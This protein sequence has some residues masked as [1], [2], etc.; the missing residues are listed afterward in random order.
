MKLAIDL[1]GTGLKLASFSG[2]KMLLKTEKPS[3]GFSMTLDESISYIIDAIKEFDLTDI[4]G[5]GIGVPSVVDA[6][7]GIVY[8][9]VNIP[10][11]KCVPVRDILSEKFHTEVYVNNDANCFAIGEYKYGALTGCRDLTGITLGTG[12]GVGIIAGGELY[13][14]ANT[15]AG[16]LGNAPYLEHN[17]E[18]YCSGNFFSAVYG[19]TGK[20]LS[21]RAAAGDA[22]ALRIWSEFGHHLG[23]FTKLVLYA[24]DPRAIT[25]GGSVAKSFGYFE[26]ALK[27][28]LDSFLYPNSL[29]NLKIAP[30]ALND[31][32]LWGAAAL[33]PE[34]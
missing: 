23:E 10:S 31:S 34:K 20:A 25:F 19:T 28:S 29:K 14:G 18:Y 3:P 1:G 33:I 5:I 26:E 13:N 21:E 32:G 4:E 30:S 22:D 6:E 16:E 11:W 8:D 15:G 17:Y 7:K 24:Y 9:V 2:G 12:L 27:K